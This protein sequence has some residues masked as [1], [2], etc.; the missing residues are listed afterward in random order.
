MRV[1][2]VVPQGF[3]DPGRPSGG[4]GYD[5]RVCAGLAESGWEVRTHTV[6]GAW[7][8]YDRAAGAGL[9]RVLTAV[10]DGATVLVDGLVASPAETPLLSHARRLR[11]V[12]LL[13]MPLATAADDR[14][15]AAALRSERAV[16]G[17]AAGVV[18]TSGWARGEVLTRFAIPAE[19][20]HV[21]RPGVDR[22]E[23]ASGT[24]DGGELLCVGAL[25]RH[26]GQDLLVDALAG[27][28][29]RDWRCLLVGPPHRDP[30]FA[31]RLR[32]RIACLGL[33]GRVRLA[34]TL[35]GAA[36]D[37][38]Y[39]GADLLVVPS[40][41]ETYGMVVTEALAHGLPVLASAVGGLPEALGFAGG[42]RPGLLVAPDDP[43][44]VRVALAAWLGDERHRRRLRAAALRRRSGLDG[45]DRTARDVAAAL[46]AP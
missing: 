22:A 28:A 26:K 23:A 6:A 34:G 39:A 45:W 30:V 12:V 43:A 16:L 8:A 37:R 40:R 3:D 21:A 27:L 18:V 19:R 2:V 20:V 46:T 17:A 9:A 36:L 38:A 24:S 11:L 42:T 41:S 15:D 31:E 10:P 44:A 25:A 1:H 14:H 33:E 7:P 35:T 4:N 13:H 5:R 32:A 29:E